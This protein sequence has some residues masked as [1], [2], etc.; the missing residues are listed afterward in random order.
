[1]STSDGGKIEIAGTDLSQNVQKAWRKIGYVAQ[2]FSL[3][4]DLTVRQNL[5]FFG[6]VYGLKN[7]RLG[8]RIQW[9]LE[10]FSLTDVA[11]RSAAKLSLGFKRRLSMACALLHEPPILFLD[12][13]TSGADPMTRYEFWR[14][15][16]ELAD[17]GVAVI[18]TTHFLDEA[19]YCD[20]M[21]I[22]QN[23]QNVASGT[24]NEI[25]QRG[26]NAPTVEEAFVR[27]LQEGRVTP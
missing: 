5:A 18:I 9:G 17:S 13:A 4:G 14:K 12:E 11:D 1:M 25:L 22:M 3:Y 7:D 19:R 20:R 15:I 10:T 27:I 6:G 24:V 8:D 21:M 26:G 23:G 16:M 2:K